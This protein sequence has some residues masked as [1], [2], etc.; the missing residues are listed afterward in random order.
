[1]HLKISSAK[2]R[3]F[4]P[5]GRL[6][7][8]YVCLYL[9]SVQRIRCTVKIWTENFEISQI[10]W[11]NWWDANSQWAET[12][13]T[14]GWDVSNLGQHVSKRDW[15]VSNQKRNKSNH[16]L[17]FTKGLYCISYSPG[18]YSWELVC[19]AII[20]N[21]KLVFGTICRTYDDS[22]IFSDILHAELCRRNMK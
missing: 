22:N 2:W 10:R 17:V 18:W 4:C 9:D 3:P 1:M 16:V 20:R 7:N 12:C 15:N 14:T 5:G 8:I 11:Q 21:F 19:I 6:V 13:R